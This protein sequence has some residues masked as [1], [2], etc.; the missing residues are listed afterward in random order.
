LSAAD[1]VAHPTSLQD[2]P[3]TSVSIKGSSFTFNEPAGAGHSLVVD[4]CTT[5][6]HSLSIY[7][8]AD[9][10]LTATPALSASILVK[11]G[12]IMS[13][14]FHGLTTTMYALMN[15]PMTPSGPIRK[16]DG[17]YVV[18]TST[19]AANIQSFSLPSRS[20]MSQ[21]IREQQPRNASLVVQFGTDGTVMSIVRRS[22]DSELLLEAENAVRQWTV[23]PILIDG[24]PVVV[25]SLLNFALD[26]DGKVRNPLAFPPESGNARP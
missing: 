15:V 13:V 7:R 14:P 23:R 6:A 20:F 8:G 5:V 21:A 12:T 1:G 22:G 4:I 24:K 11:D 16:S 26:K 25:E 18:P 9:L 2:W 17:V 19:V 3:S 10:V